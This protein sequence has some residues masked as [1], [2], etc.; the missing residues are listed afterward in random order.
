MD[1]KDDNLVTVSRY[2]VKKPH[3]IKRRECDFLRNRLLNSLKSLYIN[4]H[5]IYTL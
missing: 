4:N 2:Y 3:Y 1:L 5:W